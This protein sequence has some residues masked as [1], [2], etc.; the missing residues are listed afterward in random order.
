MTYV[1]PEQASCKTAEQG[2][3]FKEPVTMELWNA[4]DYVMEVIPSDT[5]K[6]TDVLAFKLTCVPS[7]CAFRRTSSAR[8]R[9]RA[10]ASR[11]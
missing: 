6:P 1:S 11:T 5:L 9:R 4:D 3:E 10:A 2:G 8:T 7:F